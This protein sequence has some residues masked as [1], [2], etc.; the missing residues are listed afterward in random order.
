MP[1]AL[2]TTALMHIFGEGRGQGMVI[3]GRIRLVKVLTADGNEREVK[4]GHL[5]LLARDSE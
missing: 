5:D 2:E 3:N 1:N 4:P